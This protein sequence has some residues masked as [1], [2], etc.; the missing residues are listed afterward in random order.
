[1]FLKI[2]HNECHF[3]DFFIL[4]L[5]KAGLHETLGLRYE[6]SDCRSSERWETPP[7]AYQGL[8]SAIFPG[9]QGHFWGAGF[10]GGK[11]YLV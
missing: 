7:S 2:L 10:S 3:D 8:L 6:N 4:G 5:P 11:K 9:K 1:M